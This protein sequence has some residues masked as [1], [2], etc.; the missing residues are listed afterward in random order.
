M[1]G[2]DSI[3]EPI[4][5]KIVDGVYAREYDFDMVDATDSILLVQRG[6]DKKDETVYFTEKEFN[7]ANAGAKAIIVYNNQPGMYL[8]D[9]SEA[10]T[11][12]NYKPRIPI[13]SL[14]QKD[15]I[16][17]KEMLLN[18][19]PVNG[20]LNVFYN[21]DYVAFFS[22]R[23][24]LIPLFYIKPDIVAP[25]AFVNSTDVG[26][27]YNFSSGTSFATPH[28]SGAAALLLEKYPDLQP[29]ELKAILTSTTVPV[30]DAYGNDFSIADAGAGRLDIEN[31]LNAE[32]IIE[33][34]YAII[35]FSPA[36]K[37]QTHQIMLKGIMN[38]KEIENIS[39]EIKAPKTIQT[40]HTLKNNTLTIHAT[41]IN[42]TKY[43]RHEGTIIIKHNAAKYRI[44]IIFHYVEA[45]VNI[46]EDNGLLNFEIIEPKDW[47]Y[48]K[49]IVINKKT[50]E[51][52]TT[53]LTPKRDSRITVNEPG[54][55]WIETSISTYNKAQYAYDTVRVNVA[56][57]SSSEINN[58]E[59]VFAQ[60]RISEKPI[61]IILTITALVAVVGIRFKTRKN[62]CKNYY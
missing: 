10:A 46:H 18:E 39:V 62:S 55:Y 16:E 14:S 29:G 2:V 40:D 35:T 43:D 17:L 58:L 1:L 24:P 20:S 33:P 8:G 61:Y 23:G 13:V 49:I 22:S 6:S 32:I 34:A 50:D 45:S 5:G 41:I 9:V 59:T 28:V 60:T 11:I 21:P 54:E 44:P 57:S 25:G 3:A 52:F 47:K 30:T 51:F 38:N 56:S 12:E 7:S 37:Q 27:T 19:K 36:E 42:D 48:A 26:G 31:A 15:G 4:E 53:S